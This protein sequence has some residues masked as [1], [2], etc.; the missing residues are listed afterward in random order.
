MNYNDYKTDR[1]R[2]DVAH[3]VPPQDYSV[4]MDWEDEATDPECKETLH[5]YVFDAFHTETM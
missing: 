3:L 2:A 1:E 5:H 4:L